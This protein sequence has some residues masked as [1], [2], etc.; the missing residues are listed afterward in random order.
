MKSLLLALALLPA[1][2]VAE[3]TRQLATLPAEAQESLRQEMQGSLVALNEIL[4]LMAAGKVLEAGALA[5][6]ELGLSAMGKH[7]SKPFAA[8]PGPHMPPAMHGIGMDGHKAASEFA[9]V[10]ASGDR[11][12][13]QAQLPNLTGACVA[14]HSSWR[15]R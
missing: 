7:R 11:D 10:A 6:A 5:E 3:D 2:A 15:I 8:R 9:K 13:A 14:C 1:M 12:Q 4:R